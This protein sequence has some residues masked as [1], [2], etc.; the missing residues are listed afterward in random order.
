MHGKLY[1]PDIDLYRNRYECMHNEQTLDLRACSGL[2]TVP[3]RFRYWY[4]V[5]A[6]TQTKT[7]ASRSLL[8]MLASTSTELQR[9]MKHRH[10]SGCWR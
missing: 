5:A 8:A 10:H 3:Y 1:E 7:R 9:Q 2:E 4:V 6:V